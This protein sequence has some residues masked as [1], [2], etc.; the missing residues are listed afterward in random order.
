MITVKGKYVTNPKNIANAFNTFFTNIGPSKSKTIPQCKKNFK[1]FLTNSSLNS[2]VLKVRK[3]IFQLNNRKALGPRSIPATILKDNINVSVRP[4]TLIL[5]Q[6]FEQGIFPEILKI[7]K[8][9]P[10]H[11]KE[12]IVTV[13]NYRPISLLFVFSKIFEKAMYYRIYSFL[14]KY[15]LIIT[16]Q[17]GF[18][19]NH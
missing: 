7:V 14:C 3:P 6:S 10:I 15:K 11:K 13:N 4:L 1:N 12:N 9:L 18:C 17:F 8:V 2:F 19:S 16:N 5:N